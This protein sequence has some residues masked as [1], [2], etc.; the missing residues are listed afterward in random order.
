MTFLVQACRAGSWCFALF[1]IVSGLADIA[2]IVPHSHGTPTFWERALLNLPLIAF[3]VLLVLPYWKIRQRRLRIGLLCALG[4]GCV[5]AVGGSLL[6]IKE[7]LSGE[8][9]VS[10][11]PIAGLVI[12]VFVGTFVSAIIQKTPDKPPRRS[13]TSY[14]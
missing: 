1:V 4:I 14:P 11:I 2:G 9:E 13:L 12:V 7:G 6:A 10:I 3:A 5:I 8:K